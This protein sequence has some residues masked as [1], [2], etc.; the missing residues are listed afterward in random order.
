MRK[1]QIVGL[2]LLVYFV[3]AISANGQCVSDAKSQCVPNETMNRI[4]K[5]L[6]ELAASRDLIVKLTAQAAT[7]DAKAAAASEV[8]SK[9][10]EILA[11]DAKIMGSYDKVIALYEQTIK[12]YAD[13]VDKLTA[14]INAPKSAWQKFTQALKE[15]ALLAAGVALGR[16]L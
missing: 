10:N 7:S 9:A 2:T 14:K 12:L 11:L 5:A 1:L 8:I 16:G 6:D 3:F 13:L 15:I 4:N